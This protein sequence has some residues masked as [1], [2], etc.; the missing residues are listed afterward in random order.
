MDDSIIIFKI[1]S[2]GNNLSNIM[3][4]ICYQFVYFSAYEIAY[5]CSNLDVA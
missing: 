1:V 4:W 3:T 5:P 2:Q